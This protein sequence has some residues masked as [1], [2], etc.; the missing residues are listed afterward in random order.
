MGN[1]YKLERFFAKTDVCFSYIEE[2]RGLVEK[3]WLQVKDPKAQVREYAVTAEGRQLLA[4]GYSTLIPIV[5]FLVE[6]FWIFDLKNKA[7]VQWIF[8][9]G[10]FSVL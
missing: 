5:L 10:V 4:E 9:K 3:N 7:P 8:V 1:D 6:W 2:R